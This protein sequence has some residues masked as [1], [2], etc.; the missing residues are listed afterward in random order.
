MTKTEVAEDIK[1]SLKKEG[2]IE[3]SLISRKQLA[4][5][6]GE[7]VTTVDRKMRGL[8]RICKKFFIP[9]VAERL[10]ELRR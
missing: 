10:I 4:Q 9:E 3:P 5:Y 7:D 6:M 1:R 8:P 2:E